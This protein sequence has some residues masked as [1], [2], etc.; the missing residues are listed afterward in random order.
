V[1]RRI[2]YIVD[3][4]SF[5]GGGVSEMGLRYVAVNATWGSASQGGWALHG[6]LRSGVLWRGSSSLSSN[7]HSLVYTLRSPQGG[8]AAVIMAACTPPSCLQN[9]SLVSFRG[10]FSLSS[11]RGAANFS[12]SGSVWDLGV[13][14]YWSDD[15]D[16][17]AA[18][19]PP[20]PLFVGQQLYMLSR[21]DK[22]WG[23]WTHCAPCPVNSF[24]PA[25]SFSGSGGD[26]I[27]ACKCSYNYYGVLQRPVVDVCKGCRIRFEQDGVT[28]SPSS[29]GV[30]CSEGEFKTNVP[31]SPS[32]VDRTVD[33]TC[34]ACYS[35][36]R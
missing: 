18:G 15:Y 25:G 11:D 5:A 23:M 28:F 6:A 22:M 24:S 20:P 1:S 29:E 30:S 33:S 7:Y 17:G 9:Q 36:C 32:N 19:E 16:Y 31:C 2:Y 34:A 12:L 26:G 27:G 3:L 21:L 14:W 10:A 13:R 8:G 35:S 4:P